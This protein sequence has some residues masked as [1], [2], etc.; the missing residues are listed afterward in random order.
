MT[1]RRSISGSPVGSPKNIKKMLNFC[2]QHN[3]KPI[4]EH[5]KFNDI[6][7]AIDKV[8]SNEGQ[9]SCGFELVITTW[10]TTM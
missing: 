1:G 2:V 9:I 7:N 6:N 8:R 10:L 4:V 3:I 5:F